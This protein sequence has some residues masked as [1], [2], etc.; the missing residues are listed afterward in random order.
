V[1]GEQ[2]RHLVTQ[3]F[4]LGERKQAGEEEITLAL[5]VFDLLSCQ[6]HFAS[7]ASSLPR[8][9]EPAAACPA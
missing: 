3:H 2:A 4:D 8:Q 7:F 9:S 5:E 1:L 6:F